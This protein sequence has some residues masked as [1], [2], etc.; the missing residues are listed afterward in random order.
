MELSIDDNLLTPEIP[1][2]QLEAAKET[3]KAL[4]TNLR[5]AGLTTDTSERDG[6]VLMVTVP[7]S[8]LFE[9][10]DTELSS[11]ASQTLK[12][13]QQHLRTP[14]KYKLLIAV[15]S[16]DTGSEEYLNELTELRAEA[17]LQWLA[18]K[19]IP[20]GGIVTYGLG[21]DEPLSTRPGRQQR[22]RNRRVEFY[23]VPGPILIEQLK[24]KR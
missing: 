1:K 14:D 5:N 15:H 13:L 4:A 12:Q 17:I 24:A 21:Y 8:D 3:I 10:N 18:N 19:G 23:F 20:T 22:A 7:V 6:L 16:D 9:A 2:K 11:K